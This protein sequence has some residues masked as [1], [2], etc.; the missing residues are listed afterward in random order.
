M[1]GHYLYPLN[2]IK[3]MKI[4]FISFFVIT[5][6]GLHAQD[7]GLH[8]VKSLKASSASDLVDINRISI[9][10]NGNL[11]FAG[12]FRG[13]VDFDP[14]P[15]TTLNRTANGDDIFIGKYTADGELFNSNSLVVAGDAQTQYITEMVVKGPNVYVT[16]VVDGSASFP[17][18]VALPVNTVATN[19]NNDILLAKFDEGLLNLWAYN[20]GGAS[21]DFANGIA[22]DGSDNIYLTGQFQGTANFDPSGNGTSKVL[23]APGSQGDIFIAKY[24]T[25]GELIWAFNIGG[26]FADAGRDLKLDLSGNLI[27]TGKFNGTVDFD[28]GPGTANISSS[29]TVGSTFIA[30]YTPNGDLVW[31][32]SIIDAESVSKLALSPTDDI[33]IVGY[34]QIDNAEFDPGPGQALLPYADNLPDGFVAVYDTDGNYQWAK[35]IGGPNS[36]LEIP[37][38]VAFD[39]DGSLFVSGNGGGDID[40]NQQGSPSYVLTANSLDAF[41]AKYIAGGELDYAYLIGGAGADYANRI[42]MDGGNLLTYGRIRSTSIDFDLSG[43]TAPLTSTSMN[44][45]YFAKYD[46]TPPAL[47][48]NNTSTPELGKDLLVSITLQD[49]ESGVAGAVLDY[50]PISSNST[51]SRVTLTKKSGNRFEG[52]VPSDAFGE[53]GMEFRGVAT[54]NLGVVGNTILLNTNYTVPNEGL[55]IPQRGSGNGD[56]SDYRIISIPLT[57]YTKTVKG[58]FEDDL[59]KYDPNEY[60]LFTYGD[61]TTELKE[62]SPL[63]VGK[64]YWFIAAGS[65]RPIDTGTGATVA[66]SKLA[67]FTLQLNPGWNLIGNPYNFNISWA[68]MKSANGSLTENLRVYNGSFANGT[69]LDAF[70][71]G[72]VF[73]DDT[74]TIAFPVTKNK[75]INNGK[76]N[77]NQTEPSRKPLGTGDWEVV[78][79]LD[80][81]NASYHLGGFGMRNDAQTAYDGYDEFTLPRFGNY[82]EINHTK[83]LHGSH[84]SM[85]IVPTSLEKTWE[86]TI[87]SASSGLTTLTWNPASLSTL[88][89]ALILLDLDNQ[90]PVDMT[91]TSSYRFSTNGTHHF[92]AVYGSQEY[93]KKETGSDQFLF[94]GVSPNPASGNASITFSVPSH[95][96]PGSTV[97]VNLFTTLGQKVASF[98]YPVGKEG[99]KQEWMPLDRFPLGPGIYIVQVQF[100]NIQKQTRLLIK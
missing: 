51:F 29:P 1:A 24:N 44:D 65:D 100:G 95:A 62:S 27:V 90:W 13:T 86:F 7:L 28:P 85:D 71:G 49:P 89:N 16:G 52:T 25:N 19:G 82:L 32:K 8:Y 17:T 54:N 15:S 81:Q 78:L 83:S 60:R 5:G 66:V 75:A 30:K 21:I 18:G 76:T 34:Y 57:L 10:A 74:K 40:F 99:I 4:L 84:Y 69:Q 14:A 22:V 53:L 2:P 45:S 97:A 88:N 91:A 79:N 73:A 31:A 46:H 33:A 50:R 98:D 59:G 96:A 39:S 72:F 87:E 12:S 77:T 63:E 80:Q 9:N 23:S 36:D 68:D 37:S 20:I 70:G 93:L 11:F 6:I 41:L 61:R 38:D 26:S 43:G 42:T 58:I 47:V 48:S 55:T 35:S 3:A 94:Y 67:P 64:G 92:K 56:Q